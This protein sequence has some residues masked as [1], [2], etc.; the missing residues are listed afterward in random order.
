MSQ[1]DTK[2]NAQFVTWIL[3][4]SLTDF[5]FLAWINGQKMS[6]ICILCRSTF[7]TIVSVSDDNVNIMVW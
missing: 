4:T 6:A 1:T 5:A 7:D 2:K 3:H